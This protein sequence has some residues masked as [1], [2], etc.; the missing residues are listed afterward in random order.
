MI[1]KLKNESGKE[2]SL[3]VVQREPKAFCFAFFYSF[4]LEN[5]MCAMEETFTLP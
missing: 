1:W 2:I 4:L 5:K 3:V